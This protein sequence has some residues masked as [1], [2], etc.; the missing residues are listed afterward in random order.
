MKSL[1]FTTEESAPLSFTELYS[2]FQL[3]FMCSGSERQPHRQSC[4]KSQIQSEQLQ[5][6]IPHQELLDTRDRVYRD[7]RL[8]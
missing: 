4:Q 3:M 2:D 7:T 8:D 1:V 6:L 5:G